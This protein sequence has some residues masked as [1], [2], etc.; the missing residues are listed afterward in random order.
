MNLTTLLK[1]LREYEPFLHKKIF[2]YVFVPSIKDKEEKYTYIRVLPK[3][4]TTVISRDTFRSNKTLKFVFIDNSVTS[5]E[6]DAFYDCENL[7]HVY[8]PNSVITIEDS[9]FSEC[10]NL[11]SC[12]LYTSP[13]PR[14]RQK[15][16][17]PSSA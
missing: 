14:D 17:M 5:I 6:C 15:S 9:A 3:E 16:R 12:L 10:Q 4:G 7:T 1:N 8:I 11:R 2:D 13:S